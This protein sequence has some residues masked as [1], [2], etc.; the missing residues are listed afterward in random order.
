M[1]SGTEQKGVAAAHNVLVMSSGAL[2][3]GR[4]WLA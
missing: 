2:S 3:H 1:N 4:D